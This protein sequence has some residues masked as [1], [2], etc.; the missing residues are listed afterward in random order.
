MPFR[1]GT[2][3]PYGKSP[4]AFS[5]GAAEAGNRVAAGFFSFSGFT[6]PSGGVGDGSTTFDSREVGRRQVRVVFLV[7]WGDG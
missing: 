4:F 3:I 2:G 7:C 6:G 5:A 1:F